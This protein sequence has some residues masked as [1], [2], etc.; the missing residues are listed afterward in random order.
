MYSRAYKTEGV[1]IKRINYGE[2][3][4]ILTIF[5]KHYGKITVIAKGIRKMT[6]RKKGSLE[7]FNQSVLYLARGKN[8]DIVTEVETI[9]NFLSH[10]INFEKLGRIYYFCEVVDRLTAERVEEANIYQILVDYLEFCRKY[11]IVEIE[12]RMDE[13]LKRVLLVL[14]FIDEGRVRNNFDTESFIENLMEGKI[15]SKKIINM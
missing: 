3:D 13:D 6:S 14:G 2:A 4:K 10:K 1:I 11:N 15:K 12:K 7:L 5:T 8:F 9:N